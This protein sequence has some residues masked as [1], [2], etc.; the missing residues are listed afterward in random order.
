MDKVIVPLTSSNPSK[1]LRH[2]S[3]DA[4]LDKGC[5]VHIAK[6]SKSGHFGQFNLAII[7]LLKNFNFY[8]S[9][10][11]SLRIFGMY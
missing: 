7:N 3:Y 11:N 2:Y 5:E 6:P 4:T 8:M 10:T 1:Y 9:Y